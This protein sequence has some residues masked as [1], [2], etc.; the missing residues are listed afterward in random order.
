MC[1]GRGRPGRQVDVSVRGQPQLDYKASFRTARAA[2]RNPVSK[3][4]MK[5]QTKKIPITNNHQKKKKKNEEK[6]KEKR[7]RKKVKKEK[8][9]LAERWIV[10]DRSLVFFGPSSTKATWKALYF[11]KELRFNLICAC[12]FCGSPMCCKPTT[13]VFHSF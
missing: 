2:Y 12:V 13:T 6:W 7:E 9:E 5:K 3:T 10:G 4:K 11:K 8:K 1:E